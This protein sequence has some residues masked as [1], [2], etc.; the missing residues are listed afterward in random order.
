MSFLCFFV[1]KK[2]FKQAMFWEDTLREEQSK[3]EYFSLF[4]PFNPV[5]M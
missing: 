2:D 5:I 3:E 1:A 4:N